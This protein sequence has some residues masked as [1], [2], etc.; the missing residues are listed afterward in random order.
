MKIAVATMDGSTVSQHFGQ[1]RGFVVFEVKDGQVSGGELRTTEIT[2]HEQGACHENRGGIFDLLS[3]CSALVCGGMGGGVARTLAA[4][5]LTPAVVP[6]VE[7]MV[8]AA[9]IYLNGG[10]LKG[11]EASCGHCEH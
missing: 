1:S 6:G 4:A 3:D 5:G 8:E 9:R 2:P 7:S 11:S 10:A